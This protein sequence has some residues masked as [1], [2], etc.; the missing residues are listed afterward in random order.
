M[1]CVGMCGAIVLAYSSQGIPTSVS[2]IST[3]ASHLTYNAGRVLSYVVV[4]AIF[5]LAGRGTMTIRGVGEWFSLVVGALLIVAG[6]ILL[7]V[8]PFAQL[9]ESLP[10]VNASRSILQRLYRASFG[11]LVAL[12]KLESKFYKCRKGGAHISA[13]WAGYSAGACG[14]GIRKHL[15]ERKASPMGRQTCCSD[16]HPH[17]AD[18]SDSGARNSASMDGRRGRTWTHVIAEVRKDEFGIDRREINVAA[19]LSP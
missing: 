11:A 16:D 9:D 17:G 3:L 18:A 8:I 7:R 5:G 4:G 2:K 10:L 13:V 12:P 15:P 14:D 19:T 6:V 1:H